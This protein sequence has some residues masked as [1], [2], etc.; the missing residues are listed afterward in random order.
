MRLENAPSSVEP[1]HRASL[2]PHSLLKVLNLHCLNHIWLLSFLNLRKALTLEFLYLYVQRTVANPLVTGL[3]LLCLV[4][5]LKELHSVISTELRRY[6]PHLTSKACEVQKCGIWRLTNHNSGGINLEIRSSDLHSRRLPLSPQISPAILTLLSYCRL[7]PQF[8]LHHC[9]QVARVHLVT[10]LS[11]D[12]FF[13]GAAKLISQTILYVKPPGYWSW[14]RY[15]GGRS[16][17]SKRYN[18]DMVQTPPS[19]CCVGYGWSSIR[20]RESRPGWTRKC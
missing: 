4:Y 3:V 8:P 15:L 9:Q 6:L 16:T 19:S 13:L 2:L 11:L 12:H 10:S 17:C 5:R 7:R 14:S 18:F 20:V 1:H